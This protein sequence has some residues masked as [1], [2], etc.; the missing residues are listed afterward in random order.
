M[1][2]M[3]SKNSNNFLMK[4]IF[5]LF[6]L[7]TIYV[8]IFKF[9][10]PFHSQR[11]NYYLWKSTCKWF[12]LSLLTP[13]FAFIFPICEH[14]SSWT[15]SF[16]FTNS[17]CNASIS[18]VICDFLIKWNVGLD[19]YWHTINGQ[20]FLSHVGFVEAW[21]TFFFLKVYNSISNWKQKH[22]SQI[23]NKL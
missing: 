3:D 19:I 7:C 16:L 2:K 5:P 1:E 22:S 18:T 11:F 4:F 9:A 14:Q 21:R 12:C 17:S 8:Y 20:Y 6:F 23:F 10:F 15:N 13:S